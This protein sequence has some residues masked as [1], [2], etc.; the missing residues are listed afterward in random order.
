MKEAAAV[1]GSRD[2]E[3]PPGIVEVRT[4]EATGLLAGPH[5]PRTLRDA[6]VAGTEPSERCDQ[7]AYVSPEPQS[8]HPRSDLE[9]MDEAP[10]PGDSLPGH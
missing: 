2:F 7:H 8:H 1:Y 10:P 9:A 5:C 3:V 4:C 6:F